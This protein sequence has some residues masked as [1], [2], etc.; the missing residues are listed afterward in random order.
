VL[1]DARVHLLERERDRLARGVTGL[2]PD[3]QGPLD[4]HA[5]GAEREAALV[6]DLRVVSLG[7][8]HG[9]DEDAVLPVERA[10]EEA[11]EDADLGRGKADTVGVVHQLDHPSRDPGELVVEGLH[12]ARAHA[13]H[14]IPVLADLRERDLLAD[15]ALRLRA[16]LGVR[17]RLVVVLVFL[18]VVVVLGH[19]A[20][21]ALVPHHGL[22]LDG[23]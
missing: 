9:I 5:H 6:L 3:P 22:G 1:H 10:H 19:T 12:L 16:G 8:D 18:V 11:P 15:E 14:G 4:R 20:I 2:D 17:Q 13:Q 7:R 21:L 23:A